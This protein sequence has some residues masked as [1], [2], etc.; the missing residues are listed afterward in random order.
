MR[1]AHNTLARVVEAIC[2]HA[3]DKR[4]AG[5]LSDASFFGNLR[6]WNYHSVLAHLSDILNIPSAARTLFQPPSTRK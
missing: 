4:A 6:P 3:E 5:R 1:D 2:K